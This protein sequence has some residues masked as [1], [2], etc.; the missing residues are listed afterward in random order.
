MCDW[1]RAADISAKATQ[2]ETNRLDFGVFWPPKA[3]TGTLAPDTKPLLTGCLTLRLERLPDRS[4]VTHLRIILSRPSDEAGR[5][6]WNSQLA[7][8]EYDWMRYV[9]VWDADNRWL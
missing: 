1:T 3:P 2:A 6:F 9:R 8:P 5:E 4:L 7:F